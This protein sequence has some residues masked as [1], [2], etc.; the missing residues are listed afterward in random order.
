MVFNCTPSWYQNAIPTLQASTTELNLRYADIGL[1]FQSWLNYYP[2]K[3]TD[4]TQ[5]YTTIPVDTVPTAVVKEKGANFQRAGGFI[6]VTGTPT[7]QGLLG[8]MNFPGGDYSGVG[9]MNPQALGRGQKTLP[10]E[11]GHGFGLMHTFNGISEVQAC[12]NCYESSPSDIQGD[13]CADTPPVPRNWD[14][15]SPLSAS[16]EYADSCTYR[17]QWTNP[18]TNMMSY[19]ACPNGVF[20]SCQTKRIRCGFATRLPWVISTSK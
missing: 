13:Y 2:C 20:T 7:M 6:L 1:H 11:M 10:H 4:G 8:F 19:G 3:G 17:S 16:G 18:Y 15:T 9:F 12:S 5:D 14:C